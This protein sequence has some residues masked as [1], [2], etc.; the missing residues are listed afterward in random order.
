VFGKE[1][2]SNEVN[3][4]G[5]VLPQY[6]GRITQQPSTPSDVAPVHDF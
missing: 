4:S 6:L 5:I 1:M 2:Q 3:R